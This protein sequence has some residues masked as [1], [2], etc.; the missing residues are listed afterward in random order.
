M[1][2]KFFEKNQKLIDAIGEWLTV[3]GVGHLEFPKFDEQ[4]QEAPAYRYKKSG[5]GSVLIPIW[6]LPQIKL[7]SLIGIDAQKQKI[8][9]NTEFFLQGKS[10]NNVLLTG[11]RGSGKSSLI[12]AI[13]NQ[14]YAQG[15]RVIEV[16]RQ[17]LTDWHQLISLIQN[18]NINPQKYILYCDDL[19][20]EKNESEYK[21]LKSLLDGGFEVLPANVLIYATSNRKHLL[22]EYFADNLTYQT[23]EEEI[24]AGDAVEE[25]ISLSDR[26]GLWLS[27]YAGDQDNYLQIC[28]HWINQLRGKGNNLEKL[29]DECRAEALRW[30]LYRGSRNGRIAEQFA[31]YYC[32]KF[33]NNTYENYRR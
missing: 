19:S 26:F 7:S 8:C 33:A 5:L 2:L 9:E 25:K 27:F 12:R 15:L 17:S 14:Y 16:D 4:N 30:A 11:A 10:A 13:L 29:T 3:Q 18:Q 28:E 6:L 20:F 31:R 23:V 21:S 22:P 24:H 1:L 32:A